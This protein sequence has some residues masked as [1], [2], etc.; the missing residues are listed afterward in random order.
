MPEIEI[1][2]QLTYLKVSLNTIPGAL[3]QKLIPQDA[4]LEFTL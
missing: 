3:V 1:R 2:W 4:I